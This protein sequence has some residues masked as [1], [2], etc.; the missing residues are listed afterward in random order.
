MYSPSRSPLP[1]PSLPD[2]SGSSQCT[3]S[4]RLS[5]ASNLGWWSVSPYIIYMF[6]CCSLETSDPRLSFLNFKNSFL[7]LFKIQPTSNHVT[8]FL[9]KS[10]QEV[11]AHM[12]SWAQNPKNCILK[13]LVSCTNLFLQNYL[14]FISFIFILIL[15]APVP[16]KPTWSHSNSTLKVFLSLQP[17]AVSWLHLTTP[18]GNLIS[19]CFW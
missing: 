18:K 11:P 13:L 19:T 8:N 12:M 6:Q 4:E 17:D 14:P 15:P 3:R 16:L 9:L 7:S 10:F 2:P 5:H 1:P